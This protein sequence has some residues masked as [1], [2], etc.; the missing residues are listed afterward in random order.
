MAEGE[1]P[2]EIEVSFEDSLEV[3]LKEPLVMRSVVADGKR[4]IRTRRSSPYEISD[5]AS[6][7]LSES[8]STS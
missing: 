4:K 2:Y 3:I 6:S 1:F 8:T 5:D 7:L